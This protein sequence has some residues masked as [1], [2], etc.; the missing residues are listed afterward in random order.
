MQTVQSVQKQTALIISEAFKL[1]SGSAL[2]IEFHFLS[3]RQIMNQ[4]VAE[5]LFEIYFN[6]LYKTM[7]K[8]RE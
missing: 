4:A 7:R 8:I 6:S 2:N 3:I 5:A 1:I